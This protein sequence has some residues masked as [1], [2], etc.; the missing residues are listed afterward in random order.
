VY[1]ASSLASPLP[2]LT[3]TRALLACEALS[4]HTA[5]S[6]HRQHTRGRGK[7]VRGNSGRG[8]GGRGKSGRGKSGRSKSGRGRAVEGRALAIAFGEL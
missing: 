3:V 1:E 2:S 8:K 5:I 4:T 6:R 7:S